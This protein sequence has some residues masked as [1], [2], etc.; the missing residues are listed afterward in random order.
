MKDVGTYGMP[1]GSLFG[2]RRAERM[3]IDLPWGSPAPAQGVPCIVAERRSS[4]G[5][6]RADTRSRASPLESRL[7]LS[8]PG[9][10]AALCATPPAGYQ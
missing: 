4:D 7:N 10:T 6:N 3:Q 2:A 1:T 9:P 8:T 5:C